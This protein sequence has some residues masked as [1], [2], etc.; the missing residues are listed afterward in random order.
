MAAKTLM[1]W[2]PL[3]LADSLVHRVLQILTRGHWSLNSS[4]S[5]QMLSTC[6]PLD[7]SHP[8]LVH[9]AVAI[10]EGQGEAR[11]GLTTQ[12]PQALVK[13]VIHVRTSMRVCN[14]R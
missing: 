7:L 6:S 11:E 8:D 5:R 1:R 13:G 9:E 2:I 4:M 12:D 14:R 10:V 3:K